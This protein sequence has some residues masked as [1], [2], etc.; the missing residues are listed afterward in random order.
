MSS[1]GS[2]AAAA[3]ST[4]LPS[5]HKDHC[6]GQDAEIGNGT[7]RETC[8][9]GEHPDG[10]RTRCVNRP[11]CRSGQPRKEEIAHETRTSRRDCRTLRPDRFDESP[12]RR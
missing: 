2:S 3:E 1:W 10:T 4:A 6:D 8:L 7:N 9:A 11:K 5:Y 12:A